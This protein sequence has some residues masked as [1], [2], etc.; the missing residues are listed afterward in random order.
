MRDSSSPAFRVYSAIPRQANSA[1][2]LS[3]GLAVP[4]QDG[5]G[6][7]VILQALPLSPKLVLRDCTTDLLQVLNPSE[8]GR[9][10]DPGRTLSFKKQVDAFERALIE[11]CLLETGGSVSAVMERLDLPRR[12]L[13]DKMARL[14][15]DRRELIHGAS[16]KAI[17]ERN[18]EM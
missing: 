10:R 9:H 5:K 15:I 13:S 3:I 11:Q 12:T 4:H 2:W 8:R 6:F 1:D 16:A 14:G 18:T 17:G 7:D